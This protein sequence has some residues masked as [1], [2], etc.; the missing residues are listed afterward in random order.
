M[1]LHT[2]IKN[3]NSIVTKESVNLGHYVE[4]PANASNG[5]TESNETDEEV[6]TVFLK[7]NKNIIGLKVRFSNDVL[8]EIGFV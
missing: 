1:R 3:D 2:Y 8:T 7:S 6:K 4:T 5:S